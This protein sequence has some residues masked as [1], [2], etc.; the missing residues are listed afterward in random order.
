MYFLMWNIS[1]Y[2]GGDIVSNEAL[3]NNLYSW[4]G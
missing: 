1:L 2:S 3:L 4:M